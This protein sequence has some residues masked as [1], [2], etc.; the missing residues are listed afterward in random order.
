MVNKK[1]DIAY[2]IDF[3]IQEI[4]SIAYIAYETGGI[5]YTDSETT[6]QLIKKEH[7]GLRVE[8]L[9]SIKEI[10]KHMARTGV[11]AIIYPDYHIR[12]FRS[13]AGVKHI[14]VLH[15]QSDKRYGYRKAVGE[16]DL[17][18]IT[19]DESYERYKKSGLLN[20]GTGMLIG[21]P[22]LDRVFSGKLEKDKELKKLGL[23]PGN[24]T[25]LYAPTWSDR[26][27]NSSWHKFRKAFTNNAPEHINLIVKLH[28]NLTRYRKQEVAAFRKLLKPNKNALLV[29]FVSDI[30]P[31]MAA[32]DLLVSD[33][34][35]VTREYLAFKRPFVFLSRKPK[36]M[37]NKQKIVLWECGDVVTNTRNLWPVVENALTKPESHLHTIEK[38]FN[39]TFYKPD[40]KAAKRAGEAIFGVIGH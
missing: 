9:S 35:A 21:Y 32:S 19:G 1:T 31:I 27:R 36:W 30:V 25:V 29:D 38:H 2:Y 10:R 37:W 22:K 12:F 7:P 3:S 26:S 5:I 17:F 14:L 39:E 28:P 34:S 24:K 33:V 6:S 18:F 8:Y 40:G 4:P 23:S 20:N 15:G 11:K 16:Y 13:L